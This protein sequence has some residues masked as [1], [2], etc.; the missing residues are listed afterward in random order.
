MM[1]PKLDVTHRPGLAYQYAFDWLAVQLHASPGPVAAIAGPA[2]QLLEIR[3]R[4]PDIA[5]LDLAD[6]NARPHAD[7]QRVAEV[8]PQSHSVASSDKLWATVSWIEP[9]AT[10]RPTFDKLRHCLLPYGRLLLV[11]NG[12][13]GRRLAEQR[14]DGH[15]ATLR[16]AE[17][18]AMAAEAGFHLVGRFGLHPPRA[19]LHH[20]RGE[21]ALAMGRRDVCDRR[22]A[23][24]RRDMVAGPSG[25]GRAALVCL[26]LERAG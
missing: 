17:V 21:L 24:M 18:E 5:L 9:A 14:R 3:R 11:A 15:R 6:A 2:W 19:L 10:D 12:R 13:L 22:Q 20:Y 7:A 25:A 1:L 16:A 23:A 4:L 26:T 8:L